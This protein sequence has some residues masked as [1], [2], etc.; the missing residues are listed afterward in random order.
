MTCP[1]HM[2]ACFPACN[3]C[4]PEGKA[5]VLTDGEWCKGKNRQIPHK[6]RGR[7]KKPVENLYLNSSAIEAENAPDIE[8]EIKHKMS[9]EEAEIANRLARSGEDIFIAEGL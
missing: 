7:R 1:L 3:R 8:S 2:K 6:R 4:T 5:A 9:P